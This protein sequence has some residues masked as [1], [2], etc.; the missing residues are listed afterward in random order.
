[1]AEIVNLNQFRKAKARESDQRQAAENRVRFGRNK[2][3]K[4]ND[5]RAA[6][7][8]DALL[9]GKELEIHDSGSDASDDAKPK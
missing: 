4:E 2:V 1:M 9:S 5:R 7:R 8:R 3:E 6:E